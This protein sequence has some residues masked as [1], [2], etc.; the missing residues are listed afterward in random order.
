M[1]V[2]DFYTVVTDDA[3]LNSG[4]ES[5]FAEVEGGTAAVLRDH[6]DCRAFVKVRPFTAEERA[7]LD[8][9]V[10]MQAV[11]GMRVRRSIEVITDYTVKLLNQDRI[12]EADIRETDFVPHPNEHLRMFGHLAEHAEAVL[13]ARTAT[14]IQIDQPLLIIGDEPVIAVHDEQTAMGTAPQLGGTDLVLLQGGAG[15]A[16]APLVLLPLSP[17]TALA[18]GPPHKR[19]LPAEVSLVGD[20]AESFAADLNEHVVRAAIDWVAAHPDHS[21][22]ARMKMPALEPI[23]KVSDYGSSIAGRVNATPARRPIRRL[24]ADDVDYVLPPETSHASTGD[25]AP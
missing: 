2:R 20:D 24:R 10:A 16:N 1:A 3:E 11:R 15:F 19:D 9:F 13:K 18:Y 12:S 14:L 25:V 22:F 8:T 6:L 7:L 21:G 5:L 17:S 4:L 23:L